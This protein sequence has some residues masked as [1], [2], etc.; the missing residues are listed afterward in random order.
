MA[1]CMAKTVSDPSGLS[2]GGVAHQH[3]RQ[4]RIGRTERA[5]NVRV[6]FAGI[7]AGGAVLHEEAAV[8]RQAL[9]LRH[10]DRELGRLGAPRRRATMMSAQRSTSQAW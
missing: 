3:E 6:Q 9:L 8:E 2:G 1:V 5:E 7:P 10:D 4:I